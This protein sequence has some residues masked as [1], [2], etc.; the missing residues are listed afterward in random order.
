MPPDIGI[1]LGIEPGT[2]VTTGQKTDSAQTADLPAPKR[3]SIK[4]WE[5]GARDEDEL[6]VTGF[7]G[8]LEDPHIRPVLHVVGHPV[9][10]D[11]CA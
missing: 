8:G 11:G 10:F 3:Y 1:K 7:R 6:V 5:S 9:D 2:G 4:P